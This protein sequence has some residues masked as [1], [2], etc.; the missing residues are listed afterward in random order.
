[1]KGRRQRIINTVLI[2]GTLAVVLVIGISDNSLF[3][4]WEAVKTMNLG[5]VILA[6]LC[7]LCYLMMDAVAIHFFLRRQGY[8]VSFLRL[9]FISVVGQYYSNITP[10]ASGGQPMQIYYLHHDNVPTAIGTSAVAM[11]FFCFQ[12]MLSFLAALFWIVYGGFIHD[13]VGIYKWILI[14]GFCYNAVMVTLVTSLALYTPVIK[15]L[16]ALGIRIGT[17]FHWIKKPQDISEKLNKAVDVFHSSL[18]SYSKRPWDMVIQLIIGGMQL[19]AL[20]SVI[21]CIYRG[22]GLIEESYLHLVALNIMEFI[23][24]A[25]APLPGAS[26]ASEG[27]FSMYFGKIFPDGFAFA[28]LLLWRFFTYYISLILGVVAVAIHGVREGK[29]FREVAREDNQ[30]LDGE[31]EPED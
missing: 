10:G 3:E 31:Q 8:K 17:K 29:T 28:A 19:M 9:C 30:V 20:M 21:Y 2:L 18:T 1:M 5:W 16:I 27:V 12:F 14:V 24:A 22:L 26:G 6:I 11:R 23:S 7:F 13:N 4:A 15:K 25:Y